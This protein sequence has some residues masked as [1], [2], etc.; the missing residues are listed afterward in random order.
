VSLAFFFS[1][2]DLMNKKKKTKANDL[3]ETITTIGSLILSNKCKDMFIIV[4][5]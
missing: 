2:K 1:K 4:I 5:S 3:P